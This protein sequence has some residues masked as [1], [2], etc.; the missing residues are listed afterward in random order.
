M[1][2]AASKIR[3]S[4]DVPGFR[5][6]KAP[7][8]FVRNHHAGRVSAIAFDEL[9]SASSDQIFKKLEDKDRPFLPAEV[10]ERDKI[11]LKYG[12]PLEFSLE[13]LVDPSG[14]GKQSSANKFNPLADLHARIPKG[15]PQGIP[16]G[17]KTPTPPVSP[18][19]PLT[20]QLPDLR[21]K[22]GSN[23]PI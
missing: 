23:K 21:A 20:P 7:T 14:I 2:Q 15:A 9:R 10:I 6:G 8:N 3:K 11:K 18:S 16:S 17:P 13:Y 22:P 4:V 1:D 5:R 12:E 19:K